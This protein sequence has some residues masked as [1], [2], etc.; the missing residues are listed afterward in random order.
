MATLASSALA[1]PNT[2][3]SGLWSKVQTG[4]TVAKLSQ[5]APMLFGSNQ[6]YMTLTARPKGEVVAEGA[7]K[8]Q[9]QPTLSSKTVVPRKVQV[10]MRFNEEVQWADD[11][12]QLGVLA[13]LRDAASEALARALDL[14]V[15]HG[16]NPLTGVLLSGSPAK[17][18]DTTN[19]VEVNTANAD[20]DI[21]SA[22]ALV[23]ADGF[24]MPNGIAFD[25]SFAYKLATTRDT[26]NRK[27]YPELGTGLAVASYQGLNAAVSTTVSAPE[28][29][30]GGG[31]YAT[32]NPNV[33]AIVGDFTAIRWG[34]QQAVP[35]RKFDSGDPDGNGD[36]ARTNQ[37]A[38]R[39][40]IVYGIAIMDT[41]AFA[42][43]KDA[44]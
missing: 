37:I 19:T 11:A 35:I 44:A 18:L 33:K 10:T 21:D 38:L 39:A 32:T 43:I 9:S 31:A 5:Q 20:A 13:E 15:Y 40:E 7:N 27:L 4:S 42:V 36:L 30:I 16:I 14:I 3:A 28:A 24:Y 22:V 17:V 34:V 2:L 12:A 25:P 1:L 8:S 6:Q 26:Q 23:I 41:D 29:T